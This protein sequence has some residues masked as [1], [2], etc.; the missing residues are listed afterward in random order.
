MM[1]RARSVGPGVRQAVRA[2]GEVRPSLARSG[3]RCTTHGR[4]AIATWLLRYIDP[5]V[6]CVCGLPLKVR[7]RR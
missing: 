3:I 7:L 5:G 4:P 2:R 6:T 1:V